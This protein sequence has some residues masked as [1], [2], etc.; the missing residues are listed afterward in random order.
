MPFP[1]QE[2]NMR[3]F[4]EWLPV[5]DYEIAEGYNIEYYSNPSEFPLGTDDPNYYT[6]IWMPVK[7][8]G[9]NHGVLEKGQMTVEK[10]RSTEKVFL[11]VIFFAATIFR[12][13]IQKAEEFFRRIPFFLRYG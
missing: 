2:L 13:C 4:S 6:E 3:I 11:F 9:V 7:K 8:K 1:L 5:N 12:F 10:K